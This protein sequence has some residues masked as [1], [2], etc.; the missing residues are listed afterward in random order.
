MTGSKVLVII[1]WILRGAVSNK[2]EIKMPQ[3]INAISG[4]CVQIPCQF[5]IPDSFKGSLNKSVEAIWKKSDLSGLTVFSSKTE[6]S[7]LLKGSVIGNLLSK[8]CTTV[9]HNFPAGFNDTYFFRLQ[10][11]EPL[12]Y[13]FQQGVDIKVHKDSSPPTLTPYVEILEV[14]EGT[15]VTL[16]C[17]TALPCPS[18]QPLMQWNPRLGEQLTPSLQ[19]DEFGQTLLV[20]SQMFNATPLND[21]LKVSCSLLYNSQ[22]AERLVKTSTTLRVLYAPRNTI[23]LL[24]PSGPVSE[25]NVVTLSC[26]SEANPAV[27][28]YEWYKHIGAGNLMLKDQGKILTVIASVNAQGLYVC[29]AYNNHGTDQSM[30]VAVE[31]KSFQCSIA[32]YIMCGL[33]TFLLILITAVDLVKYKSLLKRLKQVEGMREPMTYATI[34]KTNDSSVYNIIQARRREDISW[35]L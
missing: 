34:Q 3:N 13:T 20:S 33:L 5:E 32:P 31:L 19:V 1:I 21:Q 10:G 26:H 14:L 6:V 11:P 30:V 24:S 18:Q 28:R 4:F 15:K 35:K 17:S 29:K 22:V 8:N 7:S 12:V 9:F 27:Q 2:W 25:G 16:T 23:A